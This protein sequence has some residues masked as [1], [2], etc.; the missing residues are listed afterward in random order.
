MSIPG[1]MPDLER[2]EIFSRIVA[3]DCPQDTLVLARLLSERF[4]CRGFRSDPVPRAEIETWLS[5]AQLS[6]SWCNAQPWQLVVTAGAATDRF[7]AA[8]HAQAL[9]D[10]SVPAP[11]FAFPS[12]YAGIYRERRRETAGR[13]YDAVGVPKGDR[14][15]SAQ[16]TLENFRLFGAP[17]VMIVTS[18]ARLGTYGAVDCGLFVANLLL[19]A[20]SMGIATIPQAAIALYPAL[21]RAH[22]EL[23]RERLI[24]C[25][26]SFGRADP[27]HPANSFRTNRAPI[28]AVVDHREE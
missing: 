3:A 23:P 5:L 8:L 10:P 1:A 19:I 26:I 12:E 17:H 13:L 28:E 25:G 11:D 9:G 6:A 22:F 15:A 2:P 16:Q 24:V 21:I 20:Q 7:R 27:A 18:D 14:H 4:S